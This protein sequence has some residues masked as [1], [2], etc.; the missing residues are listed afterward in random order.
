MPDEKTQQ[1]HVKL[2]QRLLPGVKDSKEF[3]LIILEIGRGSVGGYDGAFMLHQPWPGIVY[4]HP[5]NRN[6]PSAF[7]DDRNRQVLNPVGGIEA[8]SVAVGLLLK[9]LT[10]LDIDHRR[11]QRRRRNLSPV[12]AFVGFE[13][14]HLRCDCRKI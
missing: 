14:S 5:V 1:I 13:P 7:M 3:V 9:I 8:A 10:C 4:A 6:L 2:Q 11:N 12:F